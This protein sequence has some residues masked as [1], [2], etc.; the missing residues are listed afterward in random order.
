MKRTYI[1]PAIEKQVTARLAQVI[2]ASG[3]R[4]A[5]SNI[6]VHSEGK[7]GNVQAAF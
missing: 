1:H 7:S 6:D 5:S 3:G 4:S 2:C